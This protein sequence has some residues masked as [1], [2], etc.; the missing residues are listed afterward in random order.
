MLQLSVQI[1]KLRIMFL[2]SFFLHFS[3]SI[4]CFLLSSNL[5][6][7]SWTIKASLK[8]P[9]H[10][11]KM[12]WNGIHSVALHIWAFKRKNRTHFFV[13]LH[14]CCVIGLDRWRTNSNLNFWCRARYSFYLFCNFSY[15]MYTLFFLGMFFCWVFFLPELGKFLLHLGK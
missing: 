15:D 5:N 10:R 3:V 2:P 4:S 7:N 11:S 9:K 8:G 1:V 13:S 12:K 6:L 14:H